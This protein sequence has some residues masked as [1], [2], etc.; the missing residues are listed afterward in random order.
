LYT[1]KAI[2][3]S[4][5]DIVAIIIIA[6]TKQLVDETMTSMRSNLTQTTIML[7][8]IANVNIEAVLESVATHV[9]VFFTP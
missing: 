9:E 8:I 2:Q 1:W 4:S 7:I 6:T 5:D 3:I